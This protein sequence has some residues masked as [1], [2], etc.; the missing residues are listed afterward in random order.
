MTD[1]TINFT[2]NQPLYQQLYVHIKNDIL[3]GKRIAGEK[4]PS[5]RKLSTLLNVSLNTVDAAYQQLLA[6]GYIESRPRRG[7]FINEI[8]P[9]HPF[10]QA[11]HFQHKP[12]TKQPDK[13]INFSQGDIDLEHFPHKAWRK[14]TIAALDNPQSLQLGENMGEIE[15]RN[16]IAD[17]LYRA[18]GV[19]CTGEQVIIG[20]GTQ[21]LLQ[22][23]LYLFPKGSTIAMEDPGFHRASLI[24]KQAGMEVV[25]IPVREHGIDVDQLDLLTSTINLV[26]CTPS[27]QFPL[28]MIMP[29]QQRQKLIQWAND[30]DGFII[31][32]DYDGE[33]RYEGK[34]I[35]SLQGLDSYGKVIYLGTFSKSLIPSLRVNYMVLPEPLLEKYKQELFYIKQTVSKIHQLT[36][37]LFIKEGHWDKHINKMRT[38]YRKKRETVIESLNHYFDTEKV[39]IKGEKSG[40]HVVIEFLDS[41]YTELEL[42]ELARKKGLKVYGTSLFYETVDYRNPEIL[43]GYSGLSIVEIERGIKHLSEV[44][45]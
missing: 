20:A 41:S 38:L 15:L 42:I 3:I 9:T 21:A 26:Y 5:K 7:L 34:P 2:K 30:N 16:Q 13:L 12:I 25:P 29:V 35:P 39:I 6:E 31:E 18:R 40:L 37:S 22:R 10:G 36:I 1:L 14:C 33:F 19:R 8:E 4:L 43:L 32:D 17:Y 44:W 28:G 24:F 45:I 11:S 23:L 27:H